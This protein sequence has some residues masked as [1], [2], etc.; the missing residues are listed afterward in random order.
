MQIS[1]TFQSL[2]SA[3]PLS[4]SLSRLPTELK[5]ALLEQ[6]RLNQQGT[7]RT[8]LSGLQRRASSLANQRLT[9]PHLTATPPLALR[10]WKGTCKVRNMA[11]TVLHCTDDVFYHSLWPSVLP[12]KSC[13]FFL[14]LAS[15]PP[16]QRKKLS[17]PPPTY[18]S[19]HRTLS[20]GKGER[21]R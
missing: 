18:H 8:Q 10:C 4:V 17:S 16:T 2:A 12:Q 14:T 6:N 5:M 3:L 11:G 20:T 13:F 7:V 21:E 9:L 15:P 19:V 1:A